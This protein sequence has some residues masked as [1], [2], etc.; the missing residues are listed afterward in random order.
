MSQLDHGTIVESWYS[1]YHR[2]ERRRLSRPK[3]LAIY[4]DGLPVR[5]QSFIQVLPVTV[6]CIYS[7]AGAITYALQQWQYQSINN[8]FQEDF[9][10]SSGF[11]DIMISYDVCRVYVYIPPVAENF[12]KKSFLSYSLDIT[13]TSWTLINLFK[14]P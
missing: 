8:N 1:F 12:T 10:N 2:T 6:L 7:P 14:H 3:W 11:P 9:Q 13:W 4:P 5:K